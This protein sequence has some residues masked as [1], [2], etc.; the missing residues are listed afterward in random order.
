MINPEAYQDVVFGLYARED[1][2]DYMGKVVI[3]NGSLIGISPIDENGHLTKTIDLPNGVYYLKELQTNEQY[4][5]DPTEYDFEV[6]YQGEAVKE[7]TIEINHGEPV[8]NYLKRGSI[9]LIKQDE[10][11]EKPL[12]NVGF[13]LATDKDFK[14]IIKTTWTDEKGRAIFDELEINHTY[15][16]REQYGNENDMIHKGY[17]YDPTI[18]EVKLHEHKEIVSVKATNQK[19]RGKV[20]FTK[21][22]ESFQSVEIIEGEFGKEH[23]PIWKQGNLLGAQ[24]TIKAAEDITTW[25]QTT[26]YKKGDVVTIIESD[27]QT[28]DSLIL[29]AGKYEAYESKTPQGYL[30][31][32]TIYEFEIEPNGKAELQLKPITINN[33]RAKVKL[34][35]TKRLAKQEVFVNEQA[36]KDVIFG[37]YAKEDISTYTGAEKIKKD[38]L[39]YALHI[40]EDGK[41]IMDDYLPS[42]EFYLKEL[43]TNEQYKLDPTAYEFKIDYEDNKEENTVTVNN[44]KPIVNELKRGSIEIIKMT[45][46]E[47]HYSKA[48]QKYA[49]SFHAMDEYAK[50]YKNPLVKEE[51]SYLAGVTFELATDET[52]EH[53]IETKKTDGDGR[54]V[55]KELELGTYYIREK[56]SLKHYVLS[57]EVFKVELTKHGQVETIEVNNELVK[58]NI[59]IHKVDE[60]NHSIALKGAE[61]TMYADQACTKKISTVVTNE[62][63]NAQFKDLSFGSTVYIKETKAPEGYELSGKVIKVTIN[64]KWL[65]KDIQHRVIEITNHKIPE[66]PNTGDNTNIA[67]Y[68]GLLGISLAAIF[69]AT[70]K[71]YM[72]R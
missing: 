11:T 54:I 46:D 14:N 37:L 39:I 24:L 33:E 13:E 44:G 29:P 31:D 59:G 2:Y 60:E 27:W 18:Y 43:K 58:A 69:M 16:I 36:Y 63:G 20:Q 23:H 21:T 10:E 52:F 72:N 15:Y 51:V 53:I 47:V 34:D 55:F 41:L 71:R 32:E 6:G 45:K 19:V 28:A 17:V 26:H 38:T 5:L 7:Y 8:Y 22:G 4:N 64:D 70:K 30:K 3:E 50:I 67:M 61:F 68:L 56:A 25:D 1:I 42:G 49:D 9:E 40:D 66:I 57:D 48:E 12:K 65:N 35:F 62:L